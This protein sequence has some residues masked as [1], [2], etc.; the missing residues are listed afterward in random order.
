MTKFQSILITKLQTPLANRFIADDDTPFG[1][2]Q[3]Y[4]AI[5]EGKTKIEPDTMS[6]D[7]DRI[8]IT[9]VGW[10]LFLGLHFQIMAQ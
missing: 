5:A 4:I 9:L 10:D 3:L 7:L 8:T 2:Q 1:H 6:D